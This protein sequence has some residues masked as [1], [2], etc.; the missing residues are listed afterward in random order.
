VCVPNGQVQ[1]REVEVTI[2][3]FRLGAGYDK[4]K[5]MVDV[6]VWKLRWRNPGLWW[7]RPLVR[8]GEDLLKTL[9]WY[10]YGDLA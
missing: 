8:L 6:R 9:E 7:S 1:S 4:V 10:N 5:D 2:L 3:M